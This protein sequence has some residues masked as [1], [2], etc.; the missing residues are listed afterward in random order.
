[1]KASSLVFVGLNGN[2]VA[3]KR[4]TG[5]IVWKRE[6]QML[7]RKFTTLLPD[8]DHLFVGYHVLVACLDARTGTSIWE[9][10]YPNSLGGGEL[11]TLK[12]EGDFL[13][14]AM[15]GEI[16]C[17][18]ARSG[19]TIWSNPLTGCGYGNASIATSRSAAPPPD[20]AA[21]TAIQAKMPHFHAFPVT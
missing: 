5:K 12:R 9:W 7:I 2:V 20:A 14:V 18:N 13:F 4:K 3:L 8:G 15:L 16:F 10:Y 1:M 17:L 19:E 6:Q 11:V 21:A